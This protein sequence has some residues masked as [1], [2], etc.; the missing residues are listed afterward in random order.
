MTEP[1]VDE[2][3]EQFV[4]RYIGVGSETVELTEVWEDYE[5]DTLRPCPKVDFKW[6]L[7]EAMP[8][9]VERELN[10]FKGVSYDFPKEG[11]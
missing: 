4:Q 10:H 5:M 8:E 2:T 7:K 9:D 1:K 6:H 11:E 3:V